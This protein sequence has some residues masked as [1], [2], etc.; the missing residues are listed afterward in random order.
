MTFRLRF[1]GIG[2]LTA[3]VLGACGKCGAPGAVADAASPDAAGKDLAACVPLMHFR[4]P[5]EECVR[6]RCCAEMN[7][8]FSGAACIDLNDCVR[9][10]GE[11]ASERGDGAAREGECPADCER[12]HPGEVV[13]FH[14]WDECVSSRC[15]SE[16]PL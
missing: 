4:A 12:R 7:A 15:A 14:A 8:C 9:T 16:C 10:C 3:L 13:V 2:L 11:S 6:T 5:C 1:G